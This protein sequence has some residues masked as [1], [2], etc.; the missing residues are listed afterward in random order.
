MRMFIAAS[1]VLQI[2]QEGIMTDSYFCTWCGLESDNNVKCEYCG[3]DK[4]SKGIFRE[5]GK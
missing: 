2:I 1:N 5:E 3:N 4:F